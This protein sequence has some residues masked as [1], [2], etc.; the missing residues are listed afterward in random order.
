MSYTS[1]HIPFNRAALVGRE[2]EYLAQCMQNEHISGDGPFTR[3][4]S[5]L[6]E[7]ELGVPKCL[8]TTSG[9][10]ALELASLLLEIQHGDEVI[11][12]SYTFVSSINAFVLHGAFPVFVDI[13]PDTLNIDENLIEGAITPRT[14]AI[15]VVH[16]AGVAC[17][18]DAILTIA[19][20]H[21][22]AV[23]EDN[24]HGLFGKYRGRCLGTFGE[25]AI[26]S[27]HETKN[28]TCGE[29]GALLINRDTY[30]AR[31]EI[32]R[33]KGTDRSRF[34]QGLVNKYGWV[35]KGSSYLPSDLLAAFLYAQLEA[36]EFVQSS[37]RRIW[38]RYREALAGWAGANRV[39][40]MCVPDHCEQS[41]HMFY[42]LMPS[43]A[44]RTRLIDHMKAQGIMVV[45]HYLP[46]HSSFMGMRLGGKLGDCP[47]TESVSERIVRLPLYVDLSKADQQKVIDGI[48]AFDPSVC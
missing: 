13:R 5:Q 23:I 6:I 25:L 34:Y 12:P 40:L 8:L 45:F 9:T 33:E 15:V 2:L 46:L 17:E 36:R 48:R 14:R 47:V 31:A 42:M 11:V 1:A 27:F 26:Q 19:G 21:G 29:G 10:H 32:L 18:M 28:L 30:V 16:Y 20:R 7:H 44:A 3:K 43:P 37:R 39:T 38:Q 35:D 4:C 24:A 41:Y 22:I